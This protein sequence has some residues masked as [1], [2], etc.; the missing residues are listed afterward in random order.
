VRL[1]LLSLLTGL[2]GDRHN[3]NKTRTT[4]DR[5]QKIEYDKCNE[6]IPNTNT[7]PIHIKNTEKKS[8]IRQKRQNF[9][10]GSLIKRYVYYQKDQ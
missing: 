8:G 9:T 1:I 10:G 7:I 2:F 3:D 5:K 4:Q 6:T